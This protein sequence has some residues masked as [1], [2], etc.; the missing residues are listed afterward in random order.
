MDV[1]FSRTAC[2]NPAIKL[3]AA[4]V[5][6]FL[7][8]FR[9]DCLRYGTGLRVYINVKRNVNAFKFC[10]YRLYQ[11]HVDGG[12]WYYHFEVLHFSVLI[13]KGKRYSVRFLSALPKPQ[14][15]IFL[16]KTDFYISVKAK[17]VYRR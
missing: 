15:Q 16:E 11:L 3:S 5:I 13:F 14:Y 8:Y 12:F 10:F 2:T 17:P 1:N 4:I 6:A 7:R 9:I